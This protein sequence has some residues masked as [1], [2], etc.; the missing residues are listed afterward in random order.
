MKSRSGGWE[1]LSDWYD[2]KQGE[3]GDLW[4]RALIDPVLLRVV[5]ECRGKEVMDLGCGNG[6]LSRRLT[7]LGAKVTAVDASSHMIKNARAR[8]HGSGVKYVCSDA[9]SMKR[10]ASA[11]FD[12]VFANMSLMDIR[13]A[14]GAIAEVARV[15]KR[16]G[17]FV[18]SISHPC[19]DIMSNSSW[20]AEKT[21]GKQP[22][23][24]RKVR[25][26]R[27]PFAEWVPWNKEDGSKPLTASYHRPL[28]WY[29][30]AFSSRGLAI[31][32][33]EE[34]EPTREFIEKEQEQLGDLDGFGFQEV[35]LHLVIE[36]VRL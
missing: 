34:P 8:D 20:V 24:H 25:G 1:E 15:L 13:D 26:Y 4:H 31:T 18:A 32:A 14:E 10:A 12:I 35:P 21:M 3:A 23:V 36:A 28:N 17:R 5:G 7:S 33:L 11:R 27:T 29:A 19:F 2:R 22:L 16:G 9:S 6:Y 30:R